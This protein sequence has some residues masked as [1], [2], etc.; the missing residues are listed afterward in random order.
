MRRFV[1]AAE[2]GGGDRLFSSNGHFD[3]VKGTRTARDMAHVFF[4]ARNSH[5]TQKTCFAHIFV[6]LTL[7]KNDFLHKLWVR[8]VML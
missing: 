7:C 5:F 3:E 6:L 8:L 4:G 1:A 2:M